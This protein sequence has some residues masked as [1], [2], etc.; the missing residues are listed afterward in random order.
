MDTENVYTLKY[1][2]TTPA[3]QELKV[4]TLRD[5]LTARD[6]REVNRRTDKP[7]DYEM[8]G[9]SVLSGL[10]VEDILDM[11]AEDYLALRDRFFRRVGISGRVQEG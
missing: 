10:P 3:G 6:L 9:V 1:P 11:D 8:A 5:R 4:V 2:Y 7:E